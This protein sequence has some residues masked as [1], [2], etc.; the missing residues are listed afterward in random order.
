M[1][2]AF[3]AKLNIASTSGG[4]PLLIG[5]PGVTDRLRADG[6]FERPL[7]A[8]HQKFA[9]AEIGREAEQIQGVGAAPVQGQNRR[10]RSGAGGLIESCE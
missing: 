7:R 9:A 10:K 3:S 1:P 2:E 8:N 4:P 5:I 6:R